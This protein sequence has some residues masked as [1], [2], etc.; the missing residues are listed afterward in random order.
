MPA[1]SPPLGVQ[2]LSEAELCEALASLAALGYARLGVRAPEETL[3]ALRARVDTMLTQPEPDPGLFYQLDAESGRYEDLENGRGWE[4]PSLRYRKVEKL[5]RDALFR[6]WITH[7]LNVQL[8]RGVYPDA[9]RIT[10][11]RAILMNKPADG[12]TPL[13][14]HQDGGRFWGV[15][16]DPTLQVWLALDDAPLGG[17]CLEVLPGSH[18]GGLATPLGGLVPGPQVEAA[19]AEARAVAL[20][21]LA[22][23]V[24][25]LHNHVWHRSGRG[26]PG[27]RRRAL[28]ACYLHGDARC[29]RKKARPR[30]F[31]EVWAG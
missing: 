26:R 30:E 9:R 10:L 5:E 7:P 27:H 24:I 18:R 11:Y 3:V 29:Q 8:A 25:L 16:R 19:D 28:S 22:G 20:P 6:A 2:T 12:G 15:D 4:G 21:A 1:E 17:G 13:P 14:W 31:F 23:E